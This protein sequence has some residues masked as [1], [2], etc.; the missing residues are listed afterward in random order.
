MERVSSK[1]GRL[2]RLPGGALVPGVTTALDV[3]NKPALVPWAANAERQHCIQVAGDTINRLLNSDEV[4]TGVGLTF[5]EMEAR[6][7]QQLRENLGKQKAHLRLM[8][9]AADIGS[10][11]HGAIE[12]WIKE[13]LG[14]SVGPVPQLSEPALL[15]YMAFEDWAKKNQF[16]P[17]AAE[18]MV[19][20][21]IQGYA[22]TIDWIARIKG[23]LVVGDWKTGSAIW[24]EAILQNA[25]YLSAL[26]KQLKIEEPMQGA[27]VRFPKKIEDVKSDEPFQFRP[28]YE[29]EGHRAY[30]AFLKAL[31]LWKWLH[32]AAIP[33]TAA[34]AP[35]AVHS[36]PPRRF[37]GV[38][39][40]ETFRKPAAAR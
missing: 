36:I 16:E 18:I 28:I 5:P 8:R 7:G 37:G 27:I 3:I 38:K 24:P 10:E 2:Y 23:I 34:Q 33:Q 26:R 20:D 25:A 1:V 31:D 4:N 12:R 11:T 22:G 35:A 30:I 32:G 15:A 40:Q 14:Q 21:P 39:Q 19:F 13:K 9:Q 17:L 6:F 29:T